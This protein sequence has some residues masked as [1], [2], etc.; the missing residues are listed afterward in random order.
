MLVQRVG[1]NVVVAQIDANGVPVRVV[2]H[3]DE[4]LAVIGVREAARVKHRALHCPEGDVPY[5]AI[6][7]AIDHEGPREGREGSHF[8]SYFL[9]LLR[10]D[11]RFGRGVRVPVGIFRAVGARL[12]IIRRALR[13]GLRVGRLAAGRLRVPLRVG[14]R[15][16]RVA[17]LA[18]GSLRI[19]LCSGS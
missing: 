7:A 5:V 15:R 14:G 17:G 3:A 8:L 9:R 1:G 10:V 4:H 18:I 13:R 2:V 19:G 6:K 12:R 16:R 11:G